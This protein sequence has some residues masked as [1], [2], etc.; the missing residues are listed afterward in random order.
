VPQMSR[1][2]SLTSILDLS[3]SSP[4]VAYR[5]STV[6]N[7]AK[8]GCCFVKY[9]EMFNSAWL[10][11]STLFQLTTGAIRCNQ[12]SY[13]YSPLVLTDI[14]WLLRQWII[15]RLRLILTGFVIPIYFVF[16]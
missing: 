9:I 5:C 10:G 1:S 7:L 11:A 14:S 2:F 3:F 13:L 16:L 4:P 12:K 8:E 15:A 6:T